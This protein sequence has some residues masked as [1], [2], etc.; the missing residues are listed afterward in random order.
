MNRRDFIFALGGATA[1]WP[2]A[3]RAQQTPP[4]IGFLGPASASAMSAWTAAFVQRL[5][6]LGWI[7]SRTIRIE[8]TAGE[9]DVPTVCQRSQPNLFDSKLMS[10]SRPEPQSPY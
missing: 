6:E 10:S 1:V 2:L 8:Y 9:T 4:M 3:A 7:E 5:R